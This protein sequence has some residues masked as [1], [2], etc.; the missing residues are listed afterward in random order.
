MKIDEKLVDYVANL[1]RLE[2]SSEE[3]VQSAADLSR[4]LEY[5]DSLNEL[6][7]EGVEPMSHAFEMTNVF[8]ADVLLPSLP[9]EEIL[10]NAPKQKDGCFLVPK[11]VE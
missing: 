8:R 5:M 11:S 3:R 1:A 10:Q 7:T 6:D 9:A 2:L 4:I